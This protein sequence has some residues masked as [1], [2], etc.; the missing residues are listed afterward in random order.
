MAAPL[1]AG[2]IAGCRPP[3]FRLR[4]A[5]PNTRDDPRPDDPEFPSRGSVAG[6]C[7]SPARRPPTYCKSCTDAPNPQTHRPS[8]PHAHPPPKATRKVA[9]A[10]D[11]AGI[12][13]LLSAFRF[14][15]FPIL[16]PSV[17]QIGRA[18]V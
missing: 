18:H 6:R 16:R 3:K 8:P 17:A 14:P 10:V 13:F 1:D 4:R 15:L 7:K 12:K 11:T 9:P 2:A 5:S